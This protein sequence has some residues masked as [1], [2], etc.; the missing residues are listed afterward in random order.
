MWHKWVLSSLKG[1]TEDYYNS[2][3][4]SKWLFWAHWILS[5]LVV[6]RWFLLF[7]FLGKDLSRLQHCITLYLITQ[8]LL[9][10]KNVSCVTLKYLE[11]VL[12][13]RQKTQGYISSEP[14]L[15]ECMQDCGHVLAGAAPWYS[16]RGS[17]LFSSQNQLY[18]FIIGCKDAACRI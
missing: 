6:L 12:S 5:Q 2:L 15:I 13:N 4:L 14:I 10:G 16:S 3:V 1:R 18:Y 7:G 17:C 11:Y 9:I 8:K